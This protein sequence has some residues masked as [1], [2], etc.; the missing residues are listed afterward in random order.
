LFVRAGFSQQRREPGAF[1]GEIHVADRD[2]NHRSANWGF[3]RAKIRAFLQRP[4]APFD[5]MTIVA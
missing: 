4:P 5:A 3:I 2:L 1:R